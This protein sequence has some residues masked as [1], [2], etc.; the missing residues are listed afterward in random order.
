MGKFD[1][2]VVLITGG[3]RSQGRS[4]AVTFAR[5]GADVAVC[6]I[7]AQLDTVPYPMGSRAELDE[8]VKLVENE[9][10]RCVAGVADVRDLDQLQEFAARTRAELGRIMAELGEALPAGR[11]GILLASPSQA[12]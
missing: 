6:D 12:V 1:G 5:E 2:K 7:A 9:D 3:A 4:H 8:T 10:R 11:V